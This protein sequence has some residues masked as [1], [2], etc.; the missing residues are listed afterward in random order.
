[1]KRFGR[2][3]WHKWS[4]LPPEE[5]CRDDDELF[6]ALR[7]EAHGRNFDRQTAERQ[8]RIAIFDHFPA[9]GI[10]ATQPVG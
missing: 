2:T 10:P 5:S 1:M 8:I 3:P 7:P 4:G 6:Q 9:L